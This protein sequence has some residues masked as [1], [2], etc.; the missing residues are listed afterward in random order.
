MERFIVAANKSWHKE[1]FDL[2]APEIPGEWTYVGTP[3]ELT[4]ELVAT[5]SPR[6]IFFPHWSHIV[7]ESIL[8]RSDCVCFHMTDVPYGRGGSPL[9]N[10]IVRNHETT[11][12]SALKMTRKVDAGPVFCKRELSLHGSAE[13]IFRRCAR[14][15][16]DI[17]E[18]LILTNPVPVPQTGEVVEFSRRRREDG[19]LSNLSNLKEVYDYIRMLDAEGYPPAFLDNEEISYDFR[20]AK[21]VGDEIHANVVIKSKKESE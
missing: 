1:L 13:E 6:Y 7:P 4:P 12:L 8:H 5:I 2:R 9:Q 18:H 10:L 11:K 16:W 21:K 19:D 15:T 20:N 14:L 17:I 3:S